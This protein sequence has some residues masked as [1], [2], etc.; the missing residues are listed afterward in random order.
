MRAVTAGTQA[1]P[2][3]PERPGPAEYALET[4]NGTGRGAEAWWRV[5][6]SV[7]EPVIRRRVWLDQA[8]WR[9]DDRAGELS[10]II[11]PTW[12]DGPHDRAGPAASPLAGVRDYWSAAGTRLRDSAKWMAAALGAALA[13]LVGTSPLSGLRLHRP[14]LPAIVTGAVGLVLLGC[15]MFL[16]MQVMRP[17]SISF[18]DVQVSR[19]GRRWR[20][21]DPLWRW[22]Q[23][24]ESQQ[25]LYLPCGVQTLTELRQAMIVEE[26]TLIALSRGISAA[27]G[28]RD[29]V[30]LLG[31]ARKARSA[32]LRE[33]REAAA[34]VATIGE[35]YHLRYRSAWA[36]Y[37]GI[38]SGVVGAAAVIATF[39]WPG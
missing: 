35:Y 15:T 32:R 33:L 11:W 2:P 4:S 18:T 9:P 12:P 1:V 22:K 38:L 16:V 3:I 30:T 5:R 27:A 23:T 19:E 6:L 24:V 34:Q 36:T 10:V 14:P 21:G 37:G 39:A 8:G 17:R 13:A 20:L 26:I 7:E 28:D 25:D 31:E 29:R